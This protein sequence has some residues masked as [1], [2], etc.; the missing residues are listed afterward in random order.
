MVFDWSCFSSSYL[1]ISW[2]NDPNFVCVLSRIDDKVRETV[3][4]VE[5]EGILIDRIKIYA[6]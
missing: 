4:N 1:Y 2:L 6:C 5:D 3:S